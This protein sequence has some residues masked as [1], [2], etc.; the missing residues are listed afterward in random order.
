MK[1]LYTVAAALVASVVLSGSASAQAMIGGNNKSSVSAKSW[2]GSGI[3]VGSQGNGSASGYTA[4][5]NVSLAGTAKASGNL[6]PISGTVVGAGTASVTG[7]ISESQQKGSGY[8][9]TD[10]YAGGKAR[11]SISSSTGKR[12]GYGGDR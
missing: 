2:S 7:G 5:G 10:G 11:A 8:V 6:G 3:E 1:R 4:V 9:S 12:G